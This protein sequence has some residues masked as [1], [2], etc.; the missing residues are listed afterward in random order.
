MSEQTLGRPETTFEVD[1]TTYL[2]SN[3][4][5]GTKDPVELKSIGTRMACDSL[6]E[7]T[8]QPV[9][10]NADIK[11]TKSFISGNPIKVNCIEPMSQIAIDYLPEK[12]FEYKDNKNESIYSFYD[13][14]SLNHDKTEILSGKN[15]KYIKIP[16][17]IDRNY[18]DKKEKKRIINDYIRQSLKINEK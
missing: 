17:T 5:N 7:I 3:M 15:I 6:S 4:G 8:G 11:D 1:G 18:K 10:L 14:F 16:W 9:D 2:I 12:F 13:R